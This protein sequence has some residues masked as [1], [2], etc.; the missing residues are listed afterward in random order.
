MIV[1]DEYI[2]EK[3]LGKGAFGEV[4]LT[5]VK[6]DNTKKFATKLLDRKKIESSGALK[7]VYNEYAILK[8]LDHPNIVKFESIKKTKEHYFLIIEYCNGGELSKALKKYK[9]KNGKAF[10]EEIVQYLMRQ[11]IDAFKYLHS[12]KIIHRDIKLDNIL[13]HFEDEK[14]KEELNM[15]KAIVK[16]IDFG[17]SRPVKKSD[18][19]YSTLGSP[20]N[21]DPIIL[22]KLTEPNNKVRQLGYDQK[23]D[24]WSL[25]TICYEMI[26]G[27]SAFDSEDMSEL[28]EKIEDGTYTVPTSLSKE[29]VSFLNGMLQ[30]KSSARLSCK[31]LSKH[32][33][34][35]KNIKDFQPINLNLVSKNVD[36]DKLKINVK[37]NKSIWSIFNEKD[38]EKLLKIEE[39]YEKED[40]EEKE[41]EYNNEFNN[42]INMPFEYNQAYPQDFNNN[43]YNNYNNFYGPM[44]PFSY[45]G[46]PGNQFNQMSQGISQGNEVYQGQNMNQNQQ[47]PPSI[48]ND[49]SFSGGIFSLNK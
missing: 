39:K 21:M 38:E 22:K 13:I 25:G 49:Y 4:Y 14:D 42:N 34:L 16:I 32:P 28:I 7:Y 5:S 9:K 45:Q 3:L 41:E 29:I 19:L 8:N 46:I 44:L 48:P 24:V 40:S 17:F 31:K 12:K 2:L 36:K 15:M 35:T 1:V 23:A 27:K 26:I 6:N 10:P 37:N 47:I 30:Y 33:F 11:I 18:L 20:L 43:Q